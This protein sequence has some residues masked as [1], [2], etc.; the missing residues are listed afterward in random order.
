MAGARYP[1][2]VRV[3]ASIK[4]AFK[5]DLFDRNVC[6]PLAFLPELLLNFAANAMA[7]LVGILGDLIIH[8]YIVLQLQTLLRR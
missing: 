8:A 1:G 3:P 6:S 7:T 2:F 4:C 5:G